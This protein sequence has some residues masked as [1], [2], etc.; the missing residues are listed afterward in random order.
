M[1]PLRAN[2]MT[3]L[4]QS[5]PGDVPME[6]GERTGSSAGSALRRESARALRAAARRLLK[7]DHGHG[8][9]WKVVPPITKAAVSNAA[10]CHERAHMILEARQDHWGA[11]RTAPA[12]RQPRRSSKDFLVVSSRIEKAVL[13]KSFSF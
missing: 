13:S 1:Q 12:H 6:L 11:R 2:Q 5:A 10:S 7:V 9:R 8:C 3:M 4:P